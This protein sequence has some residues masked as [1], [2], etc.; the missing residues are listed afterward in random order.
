MVN[1]TIN[2]YRPARVYYDFA[3]AHDASP[4]TGGQLAKLVRRSPAYISG[5]RHRAFMP[6]APMI[7]RFEELLGVAPRAY[8]IL[9]RRRA[10]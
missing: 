10:S 2:G 7:A 6:S 5:L 9:G 4:W 8:L 3:E 1:A